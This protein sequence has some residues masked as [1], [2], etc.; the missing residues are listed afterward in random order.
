MFMKKNT[1]EKYLTDIKTLP[2]DTREE[3]AIME[4]E[5][6]KTPLPVE[7]PKPVTVPV[8]SVTTAVAAQ[9]PDPAII[10]KEVQKSVVVKPDVKE[11]L[12]VAPGEEEEDTKKFPLSTKEIILV[13]INIFSIIFLFILLTKLPIKANELKN[14]RINEIKDQAAL[15]FEFNDINA[16]KADADSLKEL[17]LDD[18]GIVRFVNTVEQL[19]NINGSIKRVAFTSQKTVK[20]KTGN[21]GIPVVIEMTGNW[22]AIGHDMEKI[23]GLPFL[24]RPVTFES[25]QNFENP[26]LT[27]VK[28]GVLLYVKEEGGKK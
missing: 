21:S 17:F 7:K 25:K 10:K 24:F 3:S 4:S 18:S 19:K 26:A 2:D 27:D 9:R 12:P 23:Q 6:P 16:K 5:K 15:S 20:D 14:L 8:H 28:Y 13:V 22:D 1:P 11:S